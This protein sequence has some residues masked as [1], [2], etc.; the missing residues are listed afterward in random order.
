[1]S[2]EADGAGVVSRAVAKATLRLGPE[3]SGDAFAQM[4]ACGLPIYLYF[5]YALAREA[6]RE[7][8][9]V[10]GGIRAAFIFLENRCQEFP[11]EPI[12]VGIVVSQRTAALVSL[13]EAVREA[14]SREVRAKIP[15]LGSYRSLLTFELLDDEATRKRI[16]L[17]AMIDSIYE[18]PIKI[19]PEE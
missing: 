15:G 14:V 10:A 17:A 11:G 19:W 4:G 2:L 6:V 16:G 8:S 7:I 3:D 5:R 18:P 9:S 13:V 1:M 12:R